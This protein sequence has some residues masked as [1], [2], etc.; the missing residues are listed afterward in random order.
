MPGI[1]SEGGVA[2][3]LPAALQGAAQRSAFCM[4]HQCETQWSIGP[5]RRY[6]FVCGKMPLMRFTPA[7]LGAVH[8]TSARGNS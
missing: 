2:L 7:S 6:G 5:L 4:N 3:T 8:F 1:P